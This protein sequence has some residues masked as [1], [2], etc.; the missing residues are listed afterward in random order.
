[1]E[2]RLNRMSVH[3]NL[4]SKTDKRSIGY[5]NIQTLI[6]KTLKTYLLKIY[7]IPLYLGKR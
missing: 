7:T 4:F 2:T 1:M 3:Q 5:F 6:H